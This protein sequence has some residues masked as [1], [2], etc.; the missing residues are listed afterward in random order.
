ML[1]IRLDKMSA[2]QA[3]LAPEAGVILPKSKIS[4]DLLNIL[5]HDAAGASVIGK[6]V[7]AHLF[8]A[9]AA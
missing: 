6:L 5:V 7:S 1:P 3:A 9:G 2:C 4:E 8:S